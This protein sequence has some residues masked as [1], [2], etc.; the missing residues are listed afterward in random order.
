MKL[1]DVFSGLF[2]GSAVTGHVTD[3]R[4]ALAFYTKRVEMPLEIFQRNLVAAQFRNTQKLFAN[5]SLEET[6]DQ[7]AVFRGG[8]LQ[9][10]A[11]GVQ[12]QH[13]VDLSSCMGRI[14]Q[15]TKPQS[16]DSET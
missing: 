15:C 9:R 11:V 5:P 13:S 16:D 8:L 3:E 2:V 1:K 14:G 12:H 6:G 4:I 7:I 10:W